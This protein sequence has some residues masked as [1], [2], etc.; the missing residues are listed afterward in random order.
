MLYLLGGSP[1]AGKTTLSKKFTLETGIPSFGLDYLKMG[2]AR[3]APSLG[4]NPNGGDLNIAKQIW[5]IVKGM[6]ITYIE[7][8]EDCLLEGTYL[9]PEYVVELQ[10]NYNAQIRSCFMGYADMDIKEKARHIREY[11]IK[12]YEMD[13][14]SEDEKEALEKAQFLKE[15]SVFI[16]TECKKYNLTYFESATDHQKTIAD[17]VQFLRQTNA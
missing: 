4:V 14:S 13:W 8:S 1:R 9:L 3:G 5:P 6:A 11:G 17:V 15:F 2:L 10:Q 7:N 12:N 16:K